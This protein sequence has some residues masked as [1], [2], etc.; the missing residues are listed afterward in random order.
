MPLSPYLNGASMTEQ[1]KFMPMSTVHCEAPVVRRIA[2]MLDLDPAPYVDGAPLP[3][4]WHFPLLAGETRRSDLRAD[5]FPG[6]GVPMSDLGLPRLL[7]ANRTVE[8]REP[9]LIG[10]RIER[11]S[12]VQ[13][14]VQKHG[15]SG[16]MAIVTIGH[17]L[18]RAVDTPALLE[19]QTYILLKA[20]IPSP[21]ADTSPVAV[22]S[23]HQKTVRPDETLLFQYSALGFNSHKIHLDRAWARDVEGLP[24]LVVNGGLASLLLMEFLRNDLE[25][26]PARVAVRHIAPLY[27]NRS[28]TLAADRTERGWRACA[29]DDVGVLAVDMEIDV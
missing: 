4:G 6:F 13:S 1:S 8:Y 28:I 10:A 14:V 9:L 29:Y 26:V 7:L 25:I 23:A 2:A 17:A 16:P 15:A 19:T 24:D 20:S 3:C 22:R 18:H 27:C 11:I 21:K 12:R 5:G